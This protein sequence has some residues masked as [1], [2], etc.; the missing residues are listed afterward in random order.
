MA[1]TAPNEISLNQA[2]TDIAAGTLTSEA[3]VQSCIDRIDDRECTVQAWAFFDPD[4]ALAQAR[5]CDAKPA[6][7][8]LHGVPIG[9]KD[10]IDTADMPTECNSPIY[11]DHRPANDAACVANLRAAGAVIMGKTVTTEFASTFPG[12]TTNPHNAEHTPGGSSQGSAAAVADH[13]V[14]G[15]LGTQTGGSVIR[16]NAYCGTV[17]YKPAYGSYDTTG[18]KPLSPILDTVGFMVRS[19]NDVAPLSAALAGREPVTVTDNGAPNL[20]LH[21]T[22]QW[23]VAEKYVQNLLED[24]AAKFSAAGAPIRDYA[25]DEPYDN[26]QAMQRVVMAIE[27]CREFQPE[28]TNHRELLSEPF[29]GLITRGFDVTPEERGE[30]EG[31]LEHA[32]SNLPNMFE[33]GEILLTPGAPGE[34]PKGLTSTGDS[35]FNR[36]WTLL[37]TACL[38]L[39]V[40]KGPNG[41][42]IGI[43]L[44]DPLNDEARLIAAGRWCAKTLGLDLLD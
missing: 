5:E 13:M 24:C 2:A 37:G 25:F 42:P 8:L 38:Y 27:A 23:D 35:M 26:L 9:I 18:V 15:A 22:A 33:P 29:Q 32:R 11:K 16:P 4:L 20:L 6:Q 44:V 39:P 30:A 1:G 17:G 28:W 10:I 19:I 40:T 14:H 34:A 36:A 41:L 3:L 12:P 7:G 43:Q 31:L 21:R